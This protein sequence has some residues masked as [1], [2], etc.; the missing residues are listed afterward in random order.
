MSDSSSV[1]KPQFEPGDILGDW[2]VIRKLGSGGYGMVVEVLSKTGVRA[3]CK[4]EFVAGNSSQ[5]LQ[6]EVPVLQAMQGT[7]HF[8][9]LYMAGKIVF[10]DQPLNI[11][12]MTLVGK[13]LSEKRRECPDKRYSRSTAIRLGMQCLEAIRDLHHNGYIHRDVKGGNFAWNEV[14][15]SVYLLDYGFA[16]QYLIWEDST[17]QKLIHRAPRKS[18]HFLGTGRYASVNVHLRRDQGR[19]DDMWSFL[20]MLVEF[21]VGR[22]PWSNDDSD[23][24]IGVKK[25]KCGSKL[26]NHCPVEMYK[27][28]DHIRSLGVTSRPNYDYLMRVLQSICQRCGYNEADPFDFE[29]GGRHYEYIVNEQKTHEARLARQLAAA[30]RADDDQG[31]ST[32]TD[33][34]LGVGTEPYDESGPLGDHLSYDYTRSMSTRPQSL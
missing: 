27:L 25:G 5:M 26:L 15:R 23:R 14:D 22:L 16:R 3:A 2:E 21:V 12:V 24:L 30:E 29:P 28:Y 11:M 8:C 4:A 20:Y 19:R 18:A 10:N 6:K 31:C 17:C 34:A 9:R 1:R 7:H 33:D 13:P 32:G